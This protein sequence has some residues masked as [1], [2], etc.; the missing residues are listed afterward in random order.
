MHLF[1]VV[2]ESTPAIETYKWL[3]SN[4]RDLIS[5]GDVNRA[6]VYIQRKLAFKKAKDYH[7]GNVGLGL[8]PVPVTSRYCMDFS[9]PRTSCPQIPE[10]LKMIQDAPK[11]PGRFVIESLPPL[12]PS[13]LRGGILSLVCDGNGYSLES[14]LQSIKCN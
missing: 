14:K 8:H 6:S 5:F 1:Q 12:N 4:Q 13:F 2:P 7:K 9:S 10:R 11:N 3:T